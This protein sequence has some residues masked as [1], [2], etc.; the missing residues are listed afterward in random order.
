M[1]LSDLRKSGIFLRGVRGLCGATKKATPPDKF[2]HGF[3]D[4]ALPGDI[5]FLN[6]AQHIAGED[7]QVLT[8]V[9]VQA[10]DMTV[11]NQMLIEA[12]KMRSDL[13]LGN[14][15]ELATRLVLRV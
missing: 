12:L 11:L 8:V 1:V 15:N 4:G 2:C 10:L 9:E 3:R 7:M 13:E 5:T 14:G 6:L